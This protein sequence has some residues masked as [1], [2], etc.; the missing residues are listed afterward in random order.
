MIVSIGQMCENLEYST[1]WVAYS[2]FEPR[3]RQ[4]K[5]TYYEVLFG[6][7]HKYCLSRLFLTTGSIP[8]D[9]VMMV[10]WWSRISHCT[11]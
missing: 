4:D 5:M 8:I 2:Q 11:P 6:S 3:T 1:L 10:M 9:A 7:V